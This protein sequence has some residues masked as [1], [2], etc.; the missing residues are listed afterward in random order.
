MG[1]PEVSRDAVN[2]SPVGQV[3]L[4]VVVRVVDTLQCECSGKL[5]VGCV[6]GQWWSSGCL[7]LSDV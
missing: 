5:S 1:H 6:V 4:L 3:E 2:G 7:V